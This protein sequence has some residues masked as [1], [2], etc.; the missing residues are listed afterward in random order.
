MSL[1]L[2]NGLLCWLGVYCMSPELSELPRSP[3]Y[4]PGTAWKRR[5]TDMPQRPQSYIPVPLM[6]L[7]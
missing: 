3:L 6:L 7:R 5:M 1:L 2:T 4:V